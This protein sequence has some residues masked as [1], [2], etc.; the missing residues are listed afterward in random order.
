MGLFNKA[1]EDY[2]YINR[3]AGIA[4]PPPYPTPDEIAEK[5]RQH[6]EYMREHEKQLYQQRAYDFMKE[7]YMNHV[8]SGYHGPYSSEEV[9]DTF[10]MITAR[11][12]RSSQVDVDNAAHVLAIN[13]GDDEPNEDELPDTPE[14]DI[15]EE[16]ER[17]RQEEIRMALKED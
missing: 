9:Y 1:T 16:M 17:R 12:L 11:A 7:A 13:E 10:C 5:E 8:R 2:G 4:M 14:K 15:E 3:H 6:Q